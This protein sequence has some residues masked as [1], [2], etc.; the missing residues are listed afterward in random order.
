MPAKSLSPFVILFA[1]LLPPPAAG[2]VE[3]VG[4]VVGI[5][6]GDTLTLLDGSKTPHRRHRCAG[7]LAALR[8]TRASVTCRHGARPR[9]AR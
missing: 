2:A 5:A 4:T 7:A 3:W 8:T 1:L 9:R 6:D